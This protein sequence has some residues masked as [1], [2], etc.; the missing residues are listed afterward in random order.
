MLL[1]A[2]TCIG[3][4][5]PASPTVEHQL[6]EGTNVYLIPPQTFSPSDNFKGFQ[7][8]SDPYSMLMLMEIPG[9]FSEA[10]E[11]FNTEILEKK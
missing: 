4:S 6:I 9:P 1:L 3:Q 2:L 5:F 11:G 10:S 8:P 7:D